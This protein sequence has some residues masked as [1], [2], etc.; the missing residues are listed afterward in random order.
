MKKK[1]KLDKFSSCLIFQKKV[2]KLKK[3]L[4]SIFVKIKK[5]NGTIIGYGASA[6]AVTILNF[7][8]LKEKFVDYFL[9]T[10]K[11]KIDKYLPGTKIIV[12]KYSQSNMNNKNFYFLGAWNFKDEIIKKEKLFLQKGGKFILHLPK[13]RIITYSS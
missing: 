9:D 5:K 10:T 7:C 2:L 11:N 3:D 12:R 13:P 1:N 4:C 8:N 6:K